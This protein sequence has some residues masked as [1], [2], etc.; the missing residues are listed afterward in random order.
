MR[1]FTL[2]LALAAFVA[3]TVAPA[4]TPGTRG[5]GEVFFSETFGWENPADP[6]GW[7]APE[8]YYFL[9]PLDIGYNWMWWAGDRPHVANWTDDPPVRTRTQANGMIALPLDKYNMDNNNA[10]INLDNSIGFPPIDCS[11]RSSVIVRYQT[12][13]MSYS[14]ADMSLEISVD[15]WVRQAAINVN[16]GASH[17][18]RPLDKPAGEPATFE[19]NIS[20]VVA[21]M[22]N[23]Q[24]RIR[25]WNTRL[26]Y[27]A[28]DDFELAEAFNNDMRLSYVQMEWD[29][30][31]P[32]NP[33][34]WVYNI[35]KSQ[36][37][38]V[39]GFK[40]FLAPAIN[41]GEN[42]L[43][44]V[45]MD[46]NIVKNNQTVFQRDSEKRNVGILITDTAKIAEKYSPVDFGHYKINWEYKSK[47]ADDN[48]ADNKKETFFHVTDSVYSRSD[49]TNEL[50]WSMTKESYTT[51]N[52]ANL[53][54]FAGSIFPIFN[55]CEVDGIAVYITGGKADEFMW[56]K[57][58]LFKDPGEED[59]YPLIWTDYVQLDSADFNTWVYMDLQKDGESEFL[60][61]GEIVYAGIDMDNLNEDYMVRRNKG[62]E[63]GTDNSVKL[64]RSS[65]VGIFDGGFNSGLDNYY[66]KRNFMIRLFINDHSNPVDGVDLTPALASL[67]QNFPNPFSRITEISYELM[68]GSDVTIEVMDLTGRKVMDIREGFKPSGKHNLTVDAGNLESGVYF[69]TLRA[70]TFTETKQMV[71]TQ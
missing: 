53:N 28:I 55:D 62:L 10:E 49:D 48:P 69:Y 58:T 56:Y 35:P 39:G 41:F 25:W 16:F 30:G 31:D 15:N 33:M 12:H 7:T 27:W 54:H 32:E 11:Q 13:F 2:L 65:G 60:K 36:L 61:K 29:N 17:K 63:I 66:G 70:G 44:Q 3:V 21:G 45:Y 6:K 52:T 23:V 50:G 37:D 43:E 4:Q 1:K 24:M 8:G 57:F 5:N 38:G 34:S 71:I 18:D 40:N 67:G 46:L 22:P 64:V 51:E 59:P 68:N 42:D 20:D 47:V 19:A 14:V 26:Y 9:D